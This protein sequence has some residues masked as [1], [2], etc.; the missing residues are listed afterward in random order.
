[1]KY[2]L[3]DMTYV[4]A[5]EAFERTDLV[6]IPVGSNEVHGP[7]MPLGTDNNGAR[8]VAKRVGEKMN[9]MAIVAPLIPYGNAE[10]H[11]KF[12]GS[13]SLSLDT[14]IRVYR[15]VSDSFVRWGAKRRS[16]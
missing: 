7:H 6:I 2:L 1:M 4:E 5:K 9:G 15:D 16:A 10:H 11:M 14:L 8:E 3:E 13:T 12:E